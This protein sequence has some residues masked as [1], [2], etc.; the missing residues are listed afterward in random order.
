MFRRPITKRVRVTVVSSQGEQIALPRS[1]YL[2]IDE[3]ITSG[4]EPRSGYLSIADDIETPGARER[5][6][7]LA[8]R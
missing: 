4:P 2:S 7:L 1:G 3:K 6:D 8:L 5:L